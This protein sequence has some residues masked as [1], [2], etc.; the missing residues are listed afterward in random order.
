M[1]LKGHLHTFF[2]VITAILSG[3]ATPYIYPAN[4]KHSTPQLYDDAVVMDDGYRLPVRRWGN[5]SDSK[6]IVLA[7][8]GLNDYSFSFD[9][10]GDYLAE[11]GVSL[12]TYDQRGF[13]ATTGHGYWHGSQRMIDDN[14]IIL[15]LLRE[16]FP[17]MPLFLLGESMGGA[18]VLATI[19]Q[20]A[21]GVNAGIN[22]AILIAPAI[23]SRQT[24]PWYQRA[25]LWFAVHTVPAKK[26]TGEGLDLMPSDN[27]EMLR[28]M[29]QD[30]L[31]IKATRVDVLYGVTNLMDLATA[32]STDFS[33][34]SL[35]LYGKHD[36]IVPRE[37]TCQWLDK[38]PDLSLKQREIIIYENGYHMLNRDLQA[39]QVLDDI[40]NWIKIRSIQ[41][42]SL[43][44]S[45][46]EPVNVQDY[47]EALS[48]FCKKQK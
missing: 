48:E 27:I 28:A 39:K 29:G 12:I 38:L 17:D 31:V 37:P 10:T 47:D 43:S 6:A 7:V 42:K 33:Q 21:E 46:I 3:C 26:L 34:T 35:I 8:H 41:Q 40:A 2:I 11:Q 14:L 4:T 18:V 13:G 36:Q 45:D 24:M 15:H 1:P 44:A 9:S 20:Q 16:R 25:L 19:H 30:P 32:A 5:P 23:W 22:G